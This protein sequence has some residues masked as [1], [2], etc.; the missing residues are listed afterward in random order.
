MR[1]RH[2]SDRTLPFAPTSLL[3]DN[4]Q[5]VNKTMQR[6]DTADISYQVERDHTGVDVH[7]VERLRG[8]RNGL[9]GI[10]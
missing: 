9:L 10:L 5:R 6:Y 8:R 4:T 2:R 7:V 1:R 3:D